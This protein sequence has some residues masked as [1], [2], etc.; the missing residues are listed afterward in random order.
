MKAY[1]DVIYE[2]MGEKYLLQNS[3][4]KITRES[5]PEKLWPQE[6][7]CIWVYL[8]NPGII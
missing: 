5:F 7:L 8:V 1:V 6:K 4:L 2:I 3:H